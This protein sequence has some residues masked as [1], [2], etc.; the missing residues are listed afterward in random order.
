MAAERAAGYSEQI[1]V[2]CQKGPA[3][4]A[5]ATANA[6]AD[7]QGSKEVTVAET[8]LKK[9]LT[10]M[11]GEMSCLFTSSNSLLSNPP[12]Q[13]GDGTMEEKVQEE[14]TTLSRGVLN[15]RATPEPTVIQRSRPAEPKDRRHEDMPLPLPRKL[16][17]DASTKAD[18]G[19]RHWDKL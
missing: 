1:T 12:S 14:R 13:A 17:A 19:R 3:L 6:N 4:P 5:N 16:A 8:S 11:Q 2:T 9:S 10:T 7:L 15:T 18:D